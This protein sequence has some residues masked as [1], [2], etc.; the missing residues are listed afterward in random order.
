MLNDSF[1][2][3]NYKVRRCQN[4][5]NG[6][7]CGTIIKYD[8][9]SYPLCEHCKEILDKVRDIKEKRIIKITQK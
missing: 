9:Y 2:L 6:H 5:Y 4:I 1:L 3:G 7:T 8:D